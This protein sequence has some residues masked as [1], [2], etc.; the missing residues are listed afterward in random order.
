MNEA[1]AVLR[2]SNC[3]EKVLCIIEA[4]LDSGELRA[5]QPVQRLLKSHFAPR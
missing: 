2:V 5:V 4:E 3:G 1:Q